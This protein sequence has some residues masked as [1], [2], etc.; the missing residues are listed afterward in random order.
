MV[1]NKEFHQVPLQWGMLDHAYSSYVDRGVLDRATALVLLFSHSRLGSALPTP[2]HPRLTHRTLT[3][4]LSV[5]VPP[6]LLLKS[7]CLCSFVSSVYPSV[8]LGG[9]FSLSSS[10]PLLSLTLTSRT[11]STLCEPK[12]NST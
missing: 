12:V 11:I 6:S 10:P 4:S 5:S 7:F 3:F 9:V 8:S 2:L 1:L